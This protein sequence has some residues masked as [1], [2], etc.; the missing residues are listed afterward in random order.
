MKFTTPFLAVATLLGLATPGTTAEWT[1][2]GSTVCSL[3]PGQLATLEHRI[4][5]RPA[6]P[7]A[8]C[9]VS[10]QSLSRTAQN[11]SP[12][13]PCVTQPSFDAT[14]AALDQ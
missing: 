11:Y 12:L 6:T 5:L 9:V 2:N 4:R 3:H 7:A 1:Q 14:L 13:P 10:K 8:A